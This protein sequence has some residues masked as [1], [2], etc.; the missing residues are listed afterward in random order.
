MG[1]ILGD[2][3][4]LSTCKTL[5]HIAYRMAPLMRSGC[6][7]SL[8]YVVGKLLTRYQVVYLVEISSNSV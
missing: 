3:R 4:W 7:V 5:V 1:K 6:D 2:F 8:V